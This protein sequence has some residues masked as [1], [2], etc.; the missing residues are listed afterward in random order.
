MS[1]IRFQFLEKKQVQPKVTS[2]QIN[3]TPLS[4]VR[5]FSVVRPLN[6]YFMLNQHSKYVHI[7]KYTIKKIFPYK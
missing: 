5:K 7:L 4:V 3:K 1:V 6:I 2:S